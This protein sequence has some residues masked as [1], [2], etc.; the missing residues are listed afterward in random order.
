MADPLPGCWG[1]Q[2]RGPGRL[3]SSDMEGVCS[4]SFTKA[5]SFILTNNNREDAFLAF[6][7]RNVVTCTIPVGKIEQSVRKIQVAF[8]FC[9]NKNMRHTDGKVV[10]S[11]ALRDLKKKPKKPSFLKK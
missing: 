5:E 11:C 6:T 9:L 10:M 4:D 2:S 8:Q 1:T 3:A 7:S